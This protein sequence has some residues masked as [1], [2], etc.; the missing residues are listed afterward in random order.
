M[1]GPPG[2]ALTEA[3]PREC[4][5]VPG[6]IVPTCRTAFSGSK[7]F[8]CS[9]RPSTLAITAFQRGSQPCLNL[10]S[11]LL[12]S[13]GGSYPF[14]ARRLSS[15]LLRSPRS[16]TSVMSFLSLRGQVSAS[17]KLC[18]PFSGPVNVILSPETPFVYPNPRVD[19]E[20]SIL[21]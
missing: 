21:I 17:L 4:G 20:L 13:L 19:L 6:R 9:A 18:G 14:R 2:R 1:S 10:K 16:G 12:P 11:V 8:R 5:L 3:S 7:L 15:M